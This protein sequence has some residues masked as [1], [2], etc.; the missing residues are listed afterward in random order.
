MINAQPCPDSFLCR[1]LSWSALHITGNDAE[2]FLQGQMTHDINSAECVLTGLCDIKGRLVA[3]GYCLR[4]SSEEFFYCVHSSLV[5]TIQQHW[6]LYAQF[7]KVNIKS[8]DKIVCMQRQIKTEAIFAQRPDCKEQT[9]ALYTTDELE[10]YL[11]H[12]ADNIINGNCWLTNEIKQQRAHITIATAGK[13]LPQML[14][15]D[16]RDGISFSKG[17]YLG[18]EIVARTQHLGKVKRNLQLVT[19]DLTTTDLA[20]SELHTKTNDVAGIIIN[21]ANDD[22]NKTI[23]L[24]VVHDKYPAHELHL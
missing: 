3:T 9:I 5:E 18:Q 4:I 17:C 24:A 22:D 15:F 16:Q 8:S 11:Q 2:S 13:F 23:A 14:A 12:S 7:S 1:D 19:L 10:K 6:K 20:G 21:S